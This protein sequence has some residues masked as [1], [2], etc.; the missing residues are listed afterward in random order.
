MKRQGSSSDYTSAVPGLGDTAKVP[1]LYCWTAN[2]E[3]V[4]NR[5]EEIPVLSH[6]TPLLL[7]RVLSPSTL[8]W[9]NVTMDSAAKAVGNHSPPTLGLSEHLT[10][11]PPVQSRTENRESVWRVFA[12][13]LHV[14]VFVLF[15][16]LRVWNLQQGPQR[17]VSSHVGSFMLFN[18]L[19]TTFSRSFRALCS[20]SSDLFTFLFS[21][22]AK[23]CAL[24]DC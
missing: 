15:S 20:S 4:V 6:W 11:T 22:E 16:K 19:L 1:L 14:L 2:L 17:L 5:A 21:C 13:I 24:D 10:G 7:K 18:T 8:H 23:H 12:A 3:M 9:G